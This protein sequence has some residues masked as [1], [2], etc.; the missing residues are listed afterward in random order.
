MSKPAEGFSRIAVG[1]D[2]SPSSLYALEVARTRFPGAE[3]LLLH[4]V[5][6]RLTASPDIMGGMTP[7]SY[8]PALMESV[9]KSDGQQ[10]ASLVREGESHEQLVGEPVNSLLD[11]VREWQADL[12]IVG[13]HARGPLEHFFLG[14]TAEKLVARSHVPVLTVRLPRKPRAEQG[15]PR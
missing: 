9:E 5:D 11:A 1:I 3:I 10:L 13:T 2:F 14:S 4:T 6:V 7:M 15:T 8:D 12:L